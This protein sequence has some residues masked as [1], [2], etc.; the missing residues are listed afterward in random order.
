MNPSLEYLIENDGFVCPECGRQHF[1]KLKN[2]IIGENVLDCLPDTVKRLGTRPFI[3]CDRDTYAAAGE[4]VCRLLDS[5][6]ISYKLHIIERKKPAPDDRIVGEALL[7]IDKSCDLVI[8][9]GGG[10]INDTCKIIASAYGVPDIIVATAP[11]MDGFASATSSM[12]RCGFKVSVDSKCPDA[13]IGDTAILSAAPKKLI[14]SGM[15][16]MLA[17]YVSLTEWRLGQLIRG[18][19]YCPFIARL[20][21]NSLE[22]VV[23]N[24][25]AALNSD[26]DACGKVMRGLVLAGLGMN[27]AEIT[28]PASGMEH[29]ISH[30]FD[31]RALEFG[32]NS[33]LHGIQCALGTL[34]TIRA[35]ELLTEKLQK[36]GIDRERALKSVAEFSREEWFNV[37]R[38]K[39]GKG[40]EA[41][42]SNE[43]RED[44][45]NIESHAKRLDFIIAHKDE[46][47]GIIAGLPSSDEIRNFMLKVGLP[48]TAA[49]LGV[50]RGELRDAFIMAKDIRD[51]YVCGRLLWDL[52]LLEEIADEVM[53]EF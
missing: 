2:C 40:S 31:M 20:V 8:A 52:G 18:E 13:V 47:L 38:E 7:W 51:K 24:G 22:E 29:Y 33:D 41:I 11:S 25:E 34:M 17:K 46:I 37:L 3:L 6:E 50:T 14:R 30:A 19:Y 4:L 53:S 42:I 43:L 23:N 45:W 15:G 16:D 1:G 10:V 39:F 35:Y 26:R 28:R 5:A 49:E 12:E 44:K 27:Y 32:S 9:V 36:G 48:T 21:S